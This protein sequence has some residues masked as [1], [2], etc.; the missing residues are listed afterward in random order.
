MVRLYKE[1]FGRGPTKV[2]TEFAGRDVVICT[3]ENSF[4]PAERRLAEMEEHERLRETRLYLQYASEDQF[5]ETIER[6]L[7]RK[8]RAFISGIDTGADLATEVFYLEGEEERGTPPAESK[9]RG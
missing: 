6:L 5:K 7:G 9:M 4:T 2:R 8:V 3:L 1:L